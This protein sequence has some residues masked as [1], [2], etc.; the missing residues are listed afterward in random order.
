MSELFGLIA[1]CIVTLSALMT[2]IKKINPDKDAPRPFYW[3]IA[4][5]ISYCM[6]YGL[7]L[8]N[9]FGMGG[10]SIF[11]YTMAVYSLQYFVS[12]KVIDKFI[13][14]LIGGKDND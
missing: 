14:R 5:L 4:L 1:L 6:G 13:N 8:H 2:L 3:A 10:W 12:Q 11:I 7:H 9:D